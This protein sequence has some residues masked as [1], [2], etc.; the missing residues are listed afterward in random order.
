[1]PVGVELVDVQPGV[2]IHHLYV[3]YLRSQFLDRFIALGD[4]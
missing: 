4:Q 3:L 1:M 2:R